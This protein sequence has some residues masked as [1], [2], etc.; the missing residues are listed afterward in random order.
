MMKNSLPMMQDR[1][2]R[3]AYMAGL[4]RATLLLPSFIPFGLI[5]GIAAVQAGLGE[6]GAVAMSTLVYG[7]SSQAVLI[8]YLTSGAPLWVAIASGLVVN[9]RM[10]VYSAD[11][12][13]LLHQA[14][15]GQRLMW[16]L[17]LVDQSYLLSRASRDRNE[18]PGQEFAFYLGCTTA[19]W[20]GWILINAAGALLGANIPASWELEFAVPLS[21]VVMVAPSLRSAPFIVAATAGGL[22]GL[23]LFALPL[24]LGLICAGL[25]GTAAGA[26]FARKAA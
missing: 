6:V 3:Q 23:A 18:F 20:T 25:I 15:R 21:F 5:C 14:T 9:L 7:G 17:F 26:L 4:R 10:A 24:K 16:A 13:T 2:A 19:T 11:V 22:A 8:Q 1:D 12:S